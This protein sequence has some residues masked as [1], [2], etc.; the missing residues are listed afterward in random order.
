MVT[1]PICGRAAAPRAENT[2][3]PFCC[4]RCRTVDLGKWLDE[5]YRVAG[6]EALPEDGSSLPRDDA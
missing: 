3:F 4:P 5:K 6:S 1:C 2:A